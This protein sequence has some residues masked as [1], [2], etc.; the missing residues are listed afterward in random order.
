MF[1]WSVH[2]TWDSSH[3]VLTVPLPY[4]MLLVSGFAL[5]LILLFNSRQVMVCGNVLILA[6]A[7]A[8]YGFLMYGSTLAFDRASQTATIREISVLSLVHIYLSVERCRPRL[9]QHRQYHISASHTVR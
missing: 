9:R 3:F 2:S 4:I 1:S 8:F 6:A 7:I 5:L